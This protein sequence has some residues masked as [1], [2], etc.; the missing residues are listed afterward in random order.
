LA[1]TILD[2]FEPSFEDIGFEELLD[3][4]TNLKFFIQL[5]INI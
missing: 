3:W 5:K 4:G 2:S 1:I